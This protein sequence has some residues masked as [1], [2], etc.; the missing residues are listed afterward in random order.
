MLSS[1]EEKITVIGHRP[2]FTTFHKRYL[3]FEFVMGVDENKRQKTFADGKLILSVEH[4]K[5]TVSINYQGGESL[6]ECQCTIYN[7]DEHWINQLST[8]G[9]YKKESN[10]FGNYLIIYASLEN[11]SDKKIIYNKI[12]EG[13]ITVA[14]AD[15]G[16]AP[17]LAFH[18]NA[19]VAAGLNLTPA[20]SIS[21]KNKTPVAT[22]V[23]TIIDKYNASLPY[24]NGIG[25][26]SF[27]N[28]GVNAVLNNP[29]YHDD[30]IEQ[31]RLCTRDTKTRFTFQDQI[32]KIFPE[33]MTLNDY[34]R[35]L[36]TNDSNNDKIEAVEISSRNISVNNGMIGYPAYSDR[37]I[38]VRSIFN[39]SIRFGE[40]IA[41]K[42]EY[43][44]NVNGVWRYMVSLKHELSC[45]TPDG[46]WFTNIELQKDFSKKDKKGHIG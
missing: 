19:M 15:Y 1:Y 45:Y 34:E 46:P 22:V 8:L 42:S 9:Q 44:K 24:S 30:L 28:Y 43:I 38:T 21:F 23:Q 41:L 11:S 32:C 12:F 20:K 17:D 37:G 33:N 40:E 35:R 27:K 25:R 10:G 36:E 26:L 14:Y 6:P 29:N 18:V 16:S 5:A 3:K 2:T 4:L 39:H 31:I 7:M 13:G